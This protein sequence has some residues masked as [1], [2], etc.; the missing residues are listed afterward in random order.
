MTQFVRIMTKILQNHVLE[1]ARFFLNDIDIKSFKFNYENALVL[2]K[3]RRYIMKHVQWLDEVLADLKRVECIILNEKSQF[4]VKELKIVKYVC[5]VNKRHLDYAK[6]DK[7][8]NW[9]QCRD[10]IETWIFIDICV[11]YRIFIEK[12]VQIVESIYRLMKKK[13]NFNWN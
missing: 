12:F 4:C 8:M 13:M 11:Y 6:I 2:S 9:K 1:K 10:A 7:I 3:I 5:D